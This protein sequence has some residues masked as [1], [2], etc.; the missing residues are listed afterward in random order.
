MNK[1]TFTRASGIALAAAALAVVP[2]AVAT[3]GPTTVR[4]ATRLKVTKSGPSRCH[5]GIC[6][7][8]N[9]GTGRMTPYGQVTFTTVVTAD[10]NQPPCGPNSQW[11]PRIIRTIHTSKGSLV[12]HE[13]GLQCP[14][15][16]VGPRVNAVWAVDGADSTGS[17][18]GATGGGSDIAYPVQ[19]TAAS[20]GTITRA[21]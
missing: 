21:K 12:L 8:H 18:A 2:V 13:A 10:N 19:D 15:P 17:F 4:V 1:H 3:A 11:V 14:Q 20:A 5:A 9:S 7:L 16:G 6:L